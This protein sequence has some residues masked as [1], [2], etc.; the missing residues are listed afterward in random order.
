[1]N[2]YGVKH[3]VCGLSWSASKWV[4]II[5]MTSSLLYLPWSSNFPLMGRCKRHEMWFKV[6][7]ISP[8][9]RWKDDISECHLSTNDTCMP[10]FMVMYAT[11]ISSWTNQRRYVPNSISSCCGLPILS[12]TAL[13]KKISPSV[14][15]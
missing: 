11:P 2:T 5:S 14:A 10:W 9:W 12:T 3:L 15:I 6:M 1:M 8:I 7:I 13:V 4:T